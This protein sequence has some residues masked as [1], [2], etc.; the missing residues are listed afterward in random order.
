MSSTSLPST[1][2]PDPEATLQ[3][4][5][6]E[7]DFQ[8]SVDFYRSSAVLAYP[9]HDGKVSDKAAR[10]L[11]AFFRHGREMGKRV[12]NAG[13][14]PV[15]L[16]EYVNASARRGPYPLCIGEEADDIPTPLT[17]IIDRLIGT[18]A[19]SDGDQ[20]RV[21][22]LLR[23]DAEIRQQFADHAE[24]PL[25]KL[26][27]LATEVVAPPADD[28]TSSSTRQTLTEARSRLAVDGKLV[29]LSHESLVH[30]VAT[31]NGRMWLQ[32]FSEAQ[33][34]AENL[35]LQINDLLEVDFGASEESRTPDHL[36]ASV[37]KTFASELDFEALSGIMSESGRHHQMPERR[38]RRLES[39]REDLDILRKELL[40]AGTDRILEG[41]A[42]LESAADTVRQDMETM[43]RL[44]KAAQVA[45][46]EI[47]GRYREED[48]DSFFDGFG[49][50]N[51][52]DEELEMCPPCLIDAGSTFDL[53]ASSRS[54][55]MDLLAS[56]MPV[57][58]VV[59]VNEP[60]SGSTGLFVDG[61]PSA[62]A[63]TAWQATALGS[64]YVFQSPASEAE[65]IGRSALSGAEHLGPSLWSVYA[66]AES[67][68]VPLDDYLRSAIALESRAFPVFE[69][70]PGGRD[71][72]ER[73]SVDR[74][75][76]PED[77]WGCA[78][79]EVDRDGE[80]V[81]LK[82]PFSFADFLFCDSRCNDL[83]RWV[84]PEMWHES[85]TPVDEYLQSDK[86][87]E[88]ALVPFLWAADEDGYLRRVVPS[89]KVVRTMRFALERWH[90]LQELGGVNSSLA[91][92]VLE[93][94]RERFEQEKQ[95]A[96]AEIES[97][98]NAELQKTTGELARG[99]VANIAAGL[100][101]LQAAGPQPAG[102][103]GEVLP[104]SGPSVKEPSGPAAPAEPSPV[105]ESETLGDT[106]SEGD[107]AVET[108]SLDEP[109]IETVRCTTCNE[110]TNINSRLFAYDENQQAFIKDATAGTFRELV[111][112]AEKCPVRI[113]HPGKPLNPDEPDLDD[114]IERARPFL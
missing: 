4:T 74:N 85:M 69:F 109:Y 14:L 89:R 40:A 81:P 17:S 110:C 112:A 83:F 94:S 67:T 62:A 50:E 100:L 77:P 19:Q 21:R 5:T 49:V 65:S 16:Y 104:T 51:L 48:H 56:R 111:M 36:E 113:I 23:M 3:S 20:E 37:G 32:R 73:F 114:L 12:E 108:I 34:E 59:Q 2:S 60:V 61:I 13:L 30:L 7:S 93:E 24:L 55:L 47:A 39:I 27:D 1:S 103:S 75:P 106:A 26:W 97:R 98:Y 90:T 92:R 63:Q 80:L 58:V 8:E 105:G 44:S 54:L 82:V 46:L 31:I 101:G 53:S 95:E 72:A 45:R 79:L 29:G 38:R 10:D 96:I 57:K 33:R 25:S 76:H 41:S 6:G 18:D 88:P 15:S 9:E 91:A 35:A 70:N 84:G 78:D 71:W 43:A 42:G 66:G 99:I 68:I 11:L 86:S 102:L 28:A 87:E 52:T 22:L 107:D 64:A